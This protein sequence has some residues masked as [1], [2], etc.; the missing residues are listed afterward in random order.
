MYRG[1]VLIGLVVIGALIPDVASAARPLSLGFA[2]WAGAELDSDLSLAASDGASIVRVNVN[3]ST[4]APANPSPTFDASNPSDPGYN[5]SAVDQAVRMAS[6]NGLTVALTIYDAPAWAEGAGR[7]SAV[8]PGSWLVNAQDFGQFATAAAL[9]YNGSFPD[10]EQL[11]QFLPSV[12]LWQAWNEPN[13]DF[14][15]SPQWTLGSN[16]QWEAVAPVVYRS[17]LNAF[18]AAVKN[19]SASNRVI[20]AGTAPY[21][22]QPG[23]DPL[24]RERTPPVAFDRDVFCLSVAL[25]PSCSGPV[26]LDGVDNHPYSG[27]WQ[28]PD[29]P[30]A[31]ADDAAIPDMHKITDV[32]T[33]AVQAGLVLPNGQKSVWA[34]EMGWNT[35]PPNPNGVSP[36]QDARWYEEAFYMLWKQGVDTV[37]CT[38]IRDQ[39]PHPYVFQN[40][41]YYIDGTPKP[42]LVTAYQFPFVTKRWTASTVQAWGRAPASGS[43]AIQV[44]HGGVWSTLRTL[45]VG[46]DQVFYTTL[47][48]KGSA[49]LRATVG[50][51]ASLT[52]NQSA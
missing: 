1:S 10:P 25:A 31:N 23:T 16:G 49:T 5:W 38:E 50:S 26:Y 6:A 27:S 39:P 46:Q 40:G 24:G 37:M 34:S 4:V 36:A 12:G 21:G 28:G 18:Y 22:D 19:V 29:W 45:S 51:Q 8:Q 17:L 42:P 11:G 32:L 9:R 14:Y 48:L 47:T 52:W 44:M 43:L 41:L 35:N 13:L 15:L 33:A 30:A 20:M 3:W 2:T 7:P